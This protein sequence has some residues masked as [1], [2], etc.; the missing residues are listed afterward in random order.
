M[1]LAA[2]A[3]AVPV[4]A[5]AAFAHR[6]SLIGTLAMFVS[7]AA[8]FVLAFAAVIAAAIAL[9]A[10]W[11]DGR[12]G[13]GVAV[14]G[15]CLGLALLLIPAVGAWRIVMLPRIADVTTDTVDP[16][17]FAFAGM[18]G[19]RH[20]SRPPPGDIAMQRAAYP[21]ILP[22]RYPVGVIRVLEQAR[23]LAALRGWHVLDEVAPVSADGTAR[24]EAVAMT[25]LFAN[26][27]DVVIRIEPDGDGSRVDMRSASRYVRH[28]L[29]VNAARIRSFLAELDATLAGAIGT[30]E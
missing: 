26:R 20:P 14:F 19:A 1:E 18:D 28:D 25:P 13:F 8:G 9:R 23:S 15:L 16:P 24:I 11:R 3:F 4:L 5:A 2:R 22:H 21:D 30:E 17:A 10:I 7:M 29:G 27:N 6:F 12:S